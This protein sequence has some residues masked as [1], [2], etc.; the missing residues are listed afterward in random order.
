MYET[1]R[2]DGEE[3]IRFYKRILS[4]FFTLFFYLSTVVWQRSRTVALRYR[5]GIVSVCSK[6]VFT[7]NG[8]K[9]RK[10]RLHRKQSLC[11][12]NYACV[13]VC[14]YQDLHKGA[15]LYARA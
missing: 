14:V 11:M 12:N 13:C 5:A 1:S 6:A 8:V 4:N 9:R 7:R 15:A 2:T 10:C 3:K